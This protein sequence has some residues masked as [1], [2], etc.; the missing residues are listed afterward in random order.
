[1]RKDYPITVII[2]RTDKSKKAHAKAAIEQVLA[3]LQPL[4]D[5][6]LRV[7]VAVAPSTLT[8]DKRWQV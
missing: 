8:E 3:A 1:M 4:R 2:D 7:R 5:K 6:G